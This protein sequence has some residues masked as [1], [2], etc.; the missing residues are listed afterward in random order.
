VAAERRKPL[1]VTVPGGFVSEKDVH[2]RGALAFEVARYI[3]G[4][5]DRHEAGL[6]WTAKS[7]V[8]MAFV[9]SSKHWEL[10]ECGRWPSLL[11]ERGDR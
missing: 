11:G 4:N 3:D 8:W 9:G 1:S 5:Y 2:S 6:L 10:Q 7:Q